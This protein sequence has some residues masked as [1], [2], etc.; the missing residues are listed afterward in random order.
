MQYMLKRDDIRLQSWWG[1]EDIL[2]TRSDATAT[3]S[4][5]TRIV[6]LTIKSAVD[7]LESYYLFWKYFIA[8]LSLA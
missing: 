8:S 1:S 6:L 7:G 5:S 2:I 4:F 3:F